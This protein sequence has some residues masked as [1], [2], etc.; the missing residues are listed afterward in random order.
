MDYYIGNREV[1]AFGAKQ[2][3]SNIDALITPAL[4]LEDAKN[5]INI[6]P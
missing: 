5:T 2:K 6:A 4:E 1:S 3:N